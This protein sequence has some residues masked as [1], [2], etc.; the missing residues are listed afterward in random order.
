MSGFARGRL[1]WTVYGLVGYFAYMETVLG[2]SMP[3][4][5]EDLGLSYSA[6]SLHFS[7]FAAGGVLIGLL[8]DGA[9][10]KWG[11]RPVLWGG[12]GGMALGALA[13]IAS[14]VA[15]GTVSGRS[16]WACSARCSW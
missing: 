8:G 13:L 12:A 15:F 16:S 1:T 3:F 7:A 9:T 5:R 6:A 10:G 2:P 4:L 14:P 11:R